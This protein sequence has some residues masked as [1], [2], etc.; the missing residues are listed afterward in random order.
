MNTV[1][2]ILKGVGKGERVV[3]VKQVVFQSSVLV[4]WDNL[5]AI[6]LCVN[7]ALLFFVITLLRLL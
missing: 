5:N 1:Y 4:I 2:A 6:L 7:V 3:Y